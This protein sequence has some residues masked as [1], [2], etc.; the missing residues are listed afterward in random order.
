MGIRGNT[1]KARVIA[2]ATYLGALCGLLLS[3]Y[4]GSTLLQWGL[5]GVLLFALFLCPIG[6]ATLSF[7]AIA[8]TLK[9]AKPVLQASI[10][11]VVWGVGIVVAIFAGPTVAEFS[12]LYNDYIGH[13]LN[14]Y[15]LPP[16]YALI[17]S[18]NPHIPRVF[19]RH[20]WLVR[21]AIWSVGLIL[22]VLLGRHLMNF[23][24]WFF[25]S[26]GNTFA[27]YFISFFA[28]MGITLMI[29]TVVSK[30]LGLELDSLKDEEPPSPKFSSNNN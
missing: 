4:L 19:P 21:L 3:Y 14:G 23:S 30:L 17:L 12:R 7:L 28:G 2:G 1:S 22:S 15:V 8:V 25:D 18:S 20:V 11:V 27:G 13:L 5:L 24:V 26:I 29:I 16:L 10:P 9:R 6:S